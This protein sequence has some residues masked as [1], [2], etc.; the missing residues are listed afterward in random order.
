MNGK[1]AAD[2]IMAQEKKAAQ[3]TAWMKNEYVPVTSFIHTLK[4]D[5]YSRTY[6]AYQTPADY[7]LNEY[8]TAGK[9]E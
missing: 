4:F 1:S 7:Y 6:I 5:N 8:Y 2:S 9:Y 3:D